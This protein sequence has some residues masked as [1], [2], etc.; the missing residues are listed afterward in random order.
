MNRFP[1]EPVF[2]FR[3]IKPLTAAVLLLLAASGLRGY[4]AVSTL[5]SRGSDGLPGV[6]HSGRTDTTAEGIVYR[7]AHVD[8]K[9]AVFFLSRAPLAPEDTNGEVN[10]LYRFR[11]ATATVIDSPVES[12]SFPSGCTE[13]SSDIFDF[14]I[15]GAS[16]NWYVARQTSPLPPPP[17]PEYLFS[18]TIDGSKRAIFCRSGVKHIDFASS[19]NLGV[20]DTQIDDSSIRHIWLHEANTDG[21]TS[22]TADADGN[23][24]CPVISDDGSHV[25]FLSQSSN[26]AGAPG[27][28]KYDV[29]ADVTTSVVSF[30]ITELDAAVDAPHVSESSDVVC[31]SSKN[32]VIVNNDTNGKRDVFVC[33][34][35]NVERIT[36]D[37]GAQ[38]N[39]DDDSPRLSRDGRYIVFR[40]N[41]GNLIRD[42]GNGR[43]QIY[44]HDRFTRVIQCVSVTNDIAPAL[45]DRDCYAPEIS[46]NGRYVTFVTDAVNLAAP[47]M[48]DGQVN[49]HQQVYLVDTRPAVAEHHTISGRTGNAIEFYLRG[50]HPDGHELSYALQSSPSDGAVRDKDGTAVEIGILFA[51]DS[52]PWSYEPNSSSVLSDSFEFLLLSTDSLPS[53]PATV[54]MRLIP[55]GTGYIRR[56]SVSE[57]GGEGTQHAF[58]RTA[59]I[60]LGNVDVSDS[61]NRIVFDSRSSELNSENV[62]TNSDVYVHD[63]IAGRLFQISAI[64]DPASGMAAISGDGRSVVYFTDAGRQLIWQAV[65]SRSGVVLDTFTFRPESA[66]AISDDGTR[67]AFRNG[68]ALYLFDF[69]IMNAP[70]LLIANG[71][72]PQISGDGNVIAYSSLDDDMIHLFYVTSRS[73]PSFSIAG[74]EPQLSVSGRY[75]AYL[76][77]SGRPERR[78]LVSGEVVGPDVGASTNTSISGT[79]RFV[80]YTKG[81]Q[82]FRYDANLDI[83][84]AVSATATEVGDDTTFAGVL[85]SSGSVAAFAS[86]AGNLVNGDVNNKRDIFT[87]I[88][89]LPQNSLPAADAPDLIVMEDSESIS[90]PL[91]YTDA[92]GDDVETMVTEA[93]SHAGMFVLSPPVFGSAFWT[94]AYKPAADFF[95]TDSF[96][97]RLRDGSGFWTKSAS[98][99]I[100]VTNVN[101]QP[102]IDA[103]DDMT[104]VE[105]GTLRFPVIATDPDLDDLTFTVTSGVGSI[106]DGMFVYEPMHDVVSHNGDPPYTRAFSVSVMVSD[107]LLDDTTTFTVTITDQDQPP[108]IE[109]DVTLEPLA[110]RTSDNLTVRATAGDPDGDAVALSYVW[111]RDGDSAGLPDS[112]TIVSDLTA[113]NQTW[114]VAVTATAG[115][116]STVV[117]G[118]A[119]TIQNTPP[120]VSS[121]TVTVA[122]DS[123]ETIDL[124][125]SDG[126]ADSPL[127]Y[128][129]LN[130][131]EHGRL[132][133]APPSL[134]YVPDPDYFGSDAFRVIASDDT[135]DSAT[136]TITINVTPQPDA[137]ELVVEDLI[138]LSGTRTATVG[139]SQLKVEDVDEP[140][141]VANADVTV[142]INQLPV[143]GGF[144]HGGNPVSAGERIVLSAFPI[145][146]VLADALEDD[147]FVSDSAVLTVE[148]RD[149]PEGVASMPVE[150]GIYVGA[151]EISIAL[152][153][154]WNLI[155][156]QHPP[157]NRSSSDL[158]LVSGRG[159]EQMWCWDPLLQRLRAITQLQPAKAKGYW[160]FALED[161]VI[162]NLPVGVRDNG[163]VAIEPLWNLVGPVGA[164]ESVAV[165]AEVGGFAWS[166]RGDKNGFIYTDAMQEGEGYWLFF[167][168]D[169]TSQVD[170]G[171]E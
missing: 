65:A 15:F 92:E 58:D 169:G 163:M 136:A 148:H 104:V 97:Y 77:E 113:K 64:H 62:N 154:G 88:F 19:G 171:L 34:A 13:L 27:L 118:N 124:I 73:S 51:T 102:S 106:S 67:V 96:S 84:E 121:M 164:G 24:F 44:V 123:T 11:A 131:P 79:G 76:N 100:T 112:D 1:R 12:A 149:D 111:M 81:G 98:V 49:G 16:D 78:N 140:D 160:L 5:V 153:R 75:L 42:G 130:G 93:P 168:A 68:A 132:E 144:T 2:L 36:A 87:T 90:I 25:Y 129:V 4:G 107:G 61:G 29:A 54:S 165:P 80:Y 166:W 126:D 128:T 66:P 70:E 156:F 60:P 120:V 7:R 151:D 99:A 52:F 9:G 39:G 3:N 138:L 32:T 122:E 6:G 108:V 167:E 142:I 50:Q 28:L 18:L 146:F 43:Y 116:A 127:R 72:E 134:V 82:G 147:V 17:P 137:P 59:P 85:S 89:P 31:F 53:R 133:N 69:S 141:G 119:V 57:S 86:D 114:S 56:V 95:G 8:D 46:P 74:S 20:F 45:A 139:F 125:A 35:G 23:S 135:D 170:L 41:A 22:I 162:A 10:D 103:I 115:N 47:Y 94:V 48:A 71:D 30:Q 159:L 83:V 150:M 38:S 161:D 117:S 158:R 101:D 26:L 55:T 110:P 145:V 21:V 63:R 152:K 105:G 14:A 91:S 37:N 109:G 40:S 143:I 33:D 155:S 157:L